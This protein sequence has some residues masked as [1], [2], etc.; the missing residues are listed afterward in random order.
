[1]SALAGSELC[2]RLGLLLVT[3]VAGL[4]AARGKELPAGR[5]SVEGDAM[6]RW[7]L[8]I[9]S[10]VF[11]AVQ[12]GLAIW[13]WGGVSAFFSEPAFIALLGGTVLLTVAS[14]LTQ[15]NVSSGEKEDRANRW[16]LPVFTGIGLLMAWL[17]AYTDRRDMWSF[18]GEGVRWLGIGLFVAG[19]VLRIVPVFVL[20]KR[21]SGLVAIQQGHELVTRGIYR[22]IRNPSYLGLMIG[23][24]GWVLTFRSLFGILLVGLLLV[25]LVARMK[26]EERLLQEHFGDEYDAYRKH[27]YR[28]IPGIY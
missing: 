7:K 23:S 5:A 2:G 24:L 27:T 14:M 8:W 16:V 12:F 28:L 3:A 13:G 11:I 4:S 20:G 6:T 17:P 15:C 10:L 9:T 21:F 19:G 25:P 22:H 26:A 18:G 1:M